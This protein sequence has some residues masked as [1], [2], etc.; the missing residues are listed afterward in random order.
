MHIVLNAI[1]THVGGGLSVTLVLVDAFRA[2]LP[3]ARVSVLTSREPVDTA[4][5]ER[6]AGDEAVSVTRLSERL[7]PLR[8][9][10]WQR[11]RVPPRRRRGRFSTEKRLFS[12]A[13]PD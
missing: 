9:F 5:R 2:H 6:F 4:V 13:S 3:D 12:P 10:A 1:P 11:V 8:S 7:G